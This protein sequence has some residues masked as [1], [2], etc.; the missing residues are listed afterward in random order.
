MRHSAF[1]MTAAAV[2]VL[3]NTIHSVRAPATQQGGTKPAVAQNWLRIDTM[4]VKPEMWTE[5]RTLERDEVIP[6]LRKAGVASRA[7]WTT[8]EFG[9]TYELVLVRPI[10][11]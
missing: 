3:L 6:A 1:L 10:S 9:S 2:C 5:Y 4:Q 11:N 7:A 8:A